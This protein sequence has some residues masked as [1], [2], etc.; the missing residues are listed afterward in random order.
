[1]SNANNKYTH[2]AYTVRETK[3]GTFWTRLGTVFPHGK[4]G[5]F[6][7]KVAAIPLDGTIVCLPPREKPEGQEEPKSE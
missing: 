5:G 2:I 3:T 6:T 7:V 4:G 1:M